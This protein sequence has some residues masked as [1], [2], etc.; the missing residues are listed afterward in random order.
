MGLETRGMEL[1]RM[2]LKKRRMEL[3][4]K[5]RKGNINWYGFKVSR[6]NFIDTVQKCQSYGEFSN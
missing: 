1:R 6:R 5:R 3:R 4:S 2:E